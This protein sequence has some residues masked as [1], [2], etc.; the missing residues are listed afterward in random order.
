MNGVSVVLPVRNRVRTLELAARSVLMQPE[1]SELLIIDD[2]SDDGTADVAGRLCH[3]DSRVRL[4]RLTQPRGAAA[5]RNAG[6]GAASC[7]LVAFQD[8]DDVWLPGKLETQVRHLAAFPHVGLVACRVARLSATRTELIPRRVRKPLVLRMHNLLVRNVVTTQSMVVRRTTAREY[9]FDVS[10][11]RFQDW[12]FVLRVAECHTIHLLPFLGVVAVVQVDSVTADARAGAVA[13]MAVLDKHKS[14]FRTAPLALCLNALKA[15]IM[16]LAVGSP[17][18]RA[19][20]QS[21]GRELGRAGLPALMMM[22][23]GRFPGTAQAVGSLVHAGGIGRRQSALTEGSRSRTA[24][25][26]NLTTGSGG[27][28]GTER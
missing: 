17:E 15:A 28:V 6:V 22:E 16:A 1:T 18:D 26:G 25:I 9:P 7:E 13:R 20:M 19:V 12:D 27:S 24:D 3:L 8:S 2:S 14:L 23:I 11:P 4:L 5:A 21:L 10:L